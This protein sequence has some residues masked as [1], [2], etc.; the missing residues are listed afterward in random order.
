MNTFFKIQ[1]TS[2]KTVYINVTEI[3]KLESTS[4]GE[5][6]ISLSNTDLIETKSSIEDILKMI[7]DLND[8]N[9]NKPFYIQNFRNY[10]NT[11]A[12]LPDSKP[13]KTTDFATSMTKVIFR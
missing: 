4:N 1:T 13:L 5:T 3:T 7:Q 6:K 12:P 2:S 11:I 9:Y 10:Q 8:T